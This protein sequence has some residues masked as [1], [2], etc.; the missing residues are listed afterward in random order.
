MTFEEELEIF[1]TEEEGAQQYFFAYLGVRNLIAKRPEIYPLINKNSMFWITTQHAL[2]L[3][4][5]IALGRIFDSA[6]KH[7]VGRLM[8]SVERNMPAFTRVALRTRLSPNMTPAQADAYVSDAHELTVVEV[9]ELK[10]AIDVWRKIFIERYLPVRHQFAHKKF[11]EL[12]EVNELM[13]RTSVPEMQAMFGFLHSLYNALDQLHLNGRAPVLR[14][15]VFVLPPDPRPSRQYFPGEKSY[16]QAQ[17]ALNAMV[18]A[19]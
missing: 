4:S 10:K 13:T 17:D 2:L 12:S 18:P 8:N 19:E 7:N 9:R 1:R 16:W 6:S 5:F 3:S 15:I 11:S 14:E